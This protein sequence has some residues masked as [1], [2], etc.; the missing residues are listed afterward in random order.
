MIY[1]S[2]GVL[3]N[4]TGDAESRAYVIVIAKRKATK[5]KQYIEVTAKEEQFDYL[6]THRIYENVTGSRTGVDFLNLIFDDTPY[7]QYVA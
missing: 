7:K 1:L 3:R 5:H 2:C 4:V 6:E